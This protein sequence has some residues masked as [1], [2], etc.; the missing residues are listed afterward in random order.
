M[1]SLGRTA[2]GFGPNIIYPPSCSRFSKYT[3]FL[4]LPE[5]LY[6]SL[7]FDAPC[8]PQPIQRWRVQG[9]REHTACHVFLYGNRAV[10]CHGKFR[11]GGRKA[12]V[13]RAVREYLGIRGIW[14]SHPEGRRHIACSGHG[15]HQQRHCRSSM[16]LYVSTT[17]RMVSSVPDEH[18]RPHS[19]LLP[20]EPRQA[21]FSALKKFVCFLKVS[22]V[23]RALPV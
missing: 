11:I 13:H 19:L 6:F 22:A 21:N 9:Q 20:H 2:S 3:R 7:G 8:R 14:P 18:K 5:E 15:H 16:G 10:F 17:R 4:R 12:L 1:F 23:W